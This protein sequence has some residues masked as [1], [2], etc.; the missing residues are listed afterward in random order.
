M[1]AEVAAEVQQRELA[2]CRQTLAAAAAGRRGVTQGECKA[3]AYETLAG[4]LPSVLVT[5]CSP[6]PSPPPHCGW[7]LACVPAYH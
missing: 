3:Y 5:K 4:V 7:Q 2:Q 1:A 6:P